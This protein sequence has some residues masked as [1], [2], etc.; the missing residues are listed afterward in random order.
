MAKNTYGTGCFL[1]LNTG[2]KAIASKTACS[3]P[4]PPR[5]TRSSFA[6]EGSV[7]IGGAVVQWLRDGLHLI[8]R[9]VDVRKLA[10]SVPDSGGV[11]PCPR[12]PAWAPHWDP[13]ARHHRR[14]H[15]R[16]ERQ[17]HRAPRSNRPFQSAKELLRD[18]AGLGESSRNCAST[19]APR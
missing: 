9:S 11:Y 10:A 17:P 2:D 7:F 14:P 4:A 13:Y 8:R 3:R 19:A 18:A 6:L 1:L 16:L 5:S 15:P 12:S